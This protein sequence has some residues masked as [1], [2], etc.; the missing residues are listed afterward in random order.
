MRIGLDVMGGDDVPKIPLLGAKAFC[1]EY[2]DVHLVLYGQM[3]VMEAGL[4]ELGPMPANT[5][6]VHCPQ[7]IGMDEHPAIAIKQKPDSTI[8]VGLADVR[9]GKLDAFASAGNTGAVT[10]GSV[11][12]LELLEGLHRPTIGG[13]Y[14]N[15]GTYSLLIDCG[16]NTD[17]KPEYLLEF[18][19]IGQAY[20]KAVYGMAKPRVG[21]LN[22]GHEHTK[23]NNLT[24]EAYKLLNDHKDHLNF[25][26]NVEG[27]DINRQNADVFVCDG[28]TGNVL[29]KMIESYYE[30]LSA[31]LPAGL[32]LEFL[33]FE[34]VGGL[35]LLGVKG[36]V[37]IGHGSSTP[38]ALQNMLRRTRELVESRLLQKLPGELSGLT[39]TAV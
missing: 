10:A 8:A 6:M 30:Y 37:M 3:D 4:K 18:A 36:N 27:W 34:R 16:A 11:L 32:D 13:I 20:M 23:G 39:N 2:P 7:V 14:P 28:F 31:T 17:S 33:N 22:I 15:N 9:K 19:Y 12:I 35:P 1:A 29:T 24:R 5:S 38:F 26:G 21:L 25:V